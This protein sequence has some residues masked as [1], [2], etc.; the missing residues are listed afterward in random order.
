MQMFCLRLPI[1]AAVL[2]ALT[3][4]VPLS[5]QGAYGYGAPYQPANVVPVNEPG[6]AGRSVVYRDTHMPLVGPVPIRNEIVL[7]P[8][9][10]GTLLAS[11]TSSAPGK[12]FGQIEGFAIRRGVEIL[13][14][15]PASNGGPSCTLTMS[16]VRGRADSMQVSEGDGCSQWHGAA[17]GFEGTYRRAGR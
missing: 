3:G 12:G 15:Q 14:T 11:A 6:P 7:R 1:A 5:T 16:P 10:D 13:I 2:F 17:V 4:C 8:R 9:P